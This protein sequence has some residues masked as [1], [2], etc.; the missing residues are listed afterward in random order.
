MQQS[1]RHPEL[2]TR[3]HISELYSLFKSCLRSRES[4]SLQIIR[5][6]DVFFQTLEIAQCFPGVLVVLE[7]LLSTFPTYTYRTVAVPTTGT[8]RAVC[9]CT[10][11][12]HLLATCVHYTE[13]EG[14][15]R[16]HCNASLRHFGRRGSPHFHSQE[17]E[18]TRL[19]VQL[20]R[21][22]EPWARMLRRHQ[23][24]KPDKHD[25]RQR[26]LRRSAGSKRG[27]G[28]PRSVWTCAQARG[29]GTGGSPTQRLAA[30]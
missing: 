6:C 1:Y 10:E 30:D 27:S 8:G 12:C 26:R 2:Y 23:R 15:A 28:V 21:L 3:T 4:F 16:G 13:A 17:G 29:W 9:G 7:N 20:Q 5:K 18:R 11:H 19:L 14:R 25:K 24:S 22:L